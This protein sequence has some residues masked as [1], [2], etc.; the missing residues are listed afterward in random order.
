MLFPSSRAS[1]CV[2]VCRKRN[3]IAE[4]ELWRSIVFGFCSFILWIFKKLLNEVFFYDWEG[5][6]ANIDHFDKSLICQNGLKCHPCFL[7]FG[8]W[9]LFSRRILLAASFSSLLSV[10]SHVIPKQLVLFSLAH[11]YCQNPTLPTWGIVLVGEAGAS[12]FVWIEDI[13]LETCVT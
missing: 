2:C 13:S 3:E 6:F 4:G 8:Y 5:H 7:D 10:R 9:N 1:V 12:H 11:R